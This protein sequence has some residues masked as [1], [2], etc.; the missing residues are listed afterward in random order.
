LKYN[1]AETYH[2][3]NGALLTSG[4]FTHYLPSSAIC[5]AM[6]NSNIRMAKIIITCSSI[7]KILFGFRGTAANIKNIKTGTF[8][9]LALYVDGSI[10]Y[11]CNF[12][13]N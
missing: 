5:P 3:R 2:S 8:A 11:F 6:T 9:N 12:F 7:I 10:M 4:V 1:I 13:Y